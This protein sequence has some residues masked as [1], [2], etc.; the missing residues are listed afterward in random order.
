MIR[1]IG[2]TLVWVATFIALYPVLL[3]YHDAIQ[4]SQ[5]YLLQNATGYGFLVA[6]TILVA[7]LFTL[8]VCAITETEK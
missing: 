5:P 1:T 6:F 4:S 7:G 8:G 3:L 2:I